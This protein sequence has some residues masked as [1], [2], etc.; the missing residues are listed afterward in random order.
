MEIGP[1]LRAMLQNKVKFGVLVLEVAVTLAIVLNCA[2]MILEQ[3]RR[4]DRPTGIDEERL[5]A[6]S[7][8]PWDSALEETAARRQL[9][10]RDV[11]VLEAL[12]G[13]EAA[14]QITTLPLQG[15]GSSFQLRVLGQTAPDAWV[16]SPLY[17]LGPGFVETLGLELVA[18]RTLTPEDLPEGDGNSSSIVVTRDLADALFPDGDALGG[19]VD[20]GDPDNPAT[21]V[22]IVDH[23]F[24]PYGGGPME[25][26][27][28]F[29]PSWAARPTSMYYLVRAE[30]GAFDQVFASVDEALLGVHADREV[31]VRALT[32]VKGW[33][34]AENII[35]L[36]ILGTIVV[37]L[38]FVTGL[39]IFGMMSFSVTQRTRQVGTRRALGATRTAVLRHFLL[40]ATLVVALGVVLGVPMAFGLNV[41]LVNALG[42]PR[43]G[44]GLVVAMVA[45]LWLIGLLASAWPARRAARV[46]PALATRTV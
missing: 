11:E 41:A 45:G 22:G 29:Y 4:I 32:E 21:I 18:G 7:L 14:T 43:L 9:V 2:T 33:G 24:T 25:S 35:L 36:N 44:P 38:L 20:Y 12:P 1:I 37:L 39:G 26:R 31:T 10:L 15:G 6:V 3:R 16:R 27:I 23:M 28:T 19:T 17:G 42:V 13:V 30:E 34:L 40:E 5:I 46:P 8:R